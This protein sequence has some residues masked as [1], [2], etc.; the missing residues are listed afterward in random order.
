L[1]IKGLKVNNA[2]ENPVTTEKMR[3]FLNGLQLD[4]GLNRWIAKAI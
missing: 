1:S 3:F 4:Q 2:P